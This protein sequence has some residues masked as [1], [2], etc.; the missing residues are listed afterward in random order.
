M[1]TGAGDEEP[2]DKGAHDLLHIH[3]L[4]NVHGLARVPVQLALPQRVRDVL[5]LGKAQVT[6][7]EPISQQQPDTNHSVKRDLIQ[8]QTR[9]NT[10]SKET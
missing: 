7:H 5:H 2:L 10:V 1:D 8:C 6:D 4:I 9:P 3:S